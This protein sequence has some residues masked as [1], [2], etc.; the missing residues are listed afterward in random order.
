MLIAIIKLGE[1]DPPISTAGCRDLQR[2]VGLH[3]GHT[4]EWASVP[5]REIICLVAGVK[6]KASKEVVLLDSAHESTTFPLQRI[7]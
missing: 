2:Q 5:W 1:T 4:Q 3:G 6:K 7:L